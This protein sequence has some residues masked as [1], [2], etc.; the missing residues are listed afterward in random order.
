VAATTG[1]SEVSAEPARARPRRWRRYLASIA[2]LL[3]VVG[4]LAG[5]KACQIG[6]LIGFGDA[7]EQAG[8][9]PEAVASAIA[10][11]ATWEVTL[12]AVGSVTGAE[13]VSVSNEVPGTVIRIHFESGDVVTSGRALIELDASTER[14]QLTAARARRDLA[15]LVAERSRSLFGA[16]AIAREELDRAE[17]AL[18][19]AVGELDTLAAQI[20]RKT[21]RA[22]FAGRLGI[23]AVDLGQ[24]LPP[25]STI[26]TLESLDTLFVDF[27]L[28]QEQL[29][30]LRVGLPVRIA[31]QGSGRQVDGKL[32][33]ID[34]ALDLPTRSVKLRASV[35]DGRQLRS[36]MFVRVSVVLP[37]RERVVIVPATAIVHAAYGDSVF[38]IEPKLPGSPGMAV[39]PDGKVVRIARQQFV[40]VGPA[41]GDFV[42][43]AS[44]LAPGSAVV[45][46]G[47]FKLRNGSPVVVDDAHG[48]TPQLSPHPPNR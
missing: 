48:P 33:A 31:L 27:S 14:A 7:M 34:P 47:A 37:E 1:G 12:E 28:P 2:A 39:T 25:G 6:R 3:L 9:P 44:G 43:I 22:P 4:L 46:A 30:R 32:V 35:S 38:V 29:S 19:T 8:P 24:Y 11:M 45:S 17:A 13:R 20:D 10:Q 21:V 15:Q 16:S 18:A 36:G 40:R 41:R 42:A 5:I 26:T 23:R